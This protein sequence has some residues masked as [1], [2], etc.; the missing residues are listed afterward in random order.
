MVPNEEQPDSD[1]QKNVVFTCCK[2]KK[3]AIVV[4]ISC[5][6]VYHKSCTNRINNLHVISD[7]IVNC[8]KPVP[9]LDSK[10]AHSP[11]KVEEAS[12]IELENLK[13]ENRMLKRLL[14]EVEIKNKLLESNKNLLEENKKLLE[15]KIQM[16]NQEL[17]VKPKKTVNKTVYDKTQKNE[18]YSLIAKKQVSPTQIN[19]ELLNEGISNSTTN[20]RASENK[21]ERNLR[22]LEAAQ[23]SKMKD[24]INLSNQDNPSNAFKENFEHDKR[25]PFQ[26]VISKRKKTKEPKVCGEAEISEDDGSG[27]VGRELPEKK[28]WLFV[29]RVKD[30]VTEEM[31]GKYIQKKTKAEDTSNIYVKEI[32]TFNKIKDNR[33]FKVG[34]SYNL[35]ETAYTNTFWP[36][37]VVVYRFNFKKEERYLDRLRNKNHEKTNFPTDLQD[38]NFT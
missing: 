23:L 6:G 9:S 10:I 36:R 7:T 15:E 14:E 35:L 34:L 33:C 3:C 28:I 25:E 12:T 21:E 22:E 31:V 2:T 20:F 4:C 11:G 19:T 30:Q 27:F 29:A 18:S 37:G 1:I 24:V 17:E 26:M 16:I 32:D 8:C 5:G 38:Q 13:I